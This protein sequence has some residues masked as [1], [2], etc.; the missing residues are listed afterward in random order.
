MIESRNPK[1]ENLKKILHN[2]ESILI[3]YS[4]GVDSTFLLHVSSEILKERITAA[5]FISPVFP[6]SDLLRAEHFAKELKIPQIKILFDILSHEDFLKNDEMRCHFCK[7]QMVEKLQNEA[8]KQGLH[9]IVDG[10]NL[11]DLKDYRPGLKVSKEAG[12]RS[13]LLEAGFTKEDIRREA[14]ERKLDTWDTPA[15]AC[16]ASRI[17]FGTR[18]TK[19]D[20]S[21]I[22]QGEAFL[23]QLGFR[24]VRVRY[25]APVARIEISTREIP[26][27]AESTIRNKVVDTLRDLG[28]IYVT[29]D[30]S[31]YRRGSMNDLLP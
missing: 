27:L 23:H 20:L 11:D 31:G 12:I 22:E 7:T 8:K 26:Q 28:F 2:M 6:T 5:T 21:M 4:G 9:S 29:L 15:S 19:K 13:P 17:A 30:L 25:H 14:K 18:I 1:I 10:T 3:S 24:E 16:L